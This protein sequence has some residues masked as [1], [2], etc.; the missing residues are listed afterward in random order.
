MTDTAADIGYGGEFR[1]GAG[2]GPVVY[3]ALGEVTA[4]SGIAIN[5]STVEA[6]HLKSPGAFKEF[7]AGL[8][9]LSEV[10]IKFNYVPGGT[11]EGDLTDDVIARARLQYQIFWPG[12]DGGTWSFKA[13]PTGFTPAGLTPEGKMEGEAKFKP[14]GAPTIAAV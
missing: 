9:D 5:G 8:L 6:T 7:I 2:S 13:I 11:L 10:T 14:S 1:K 12:T 3:T 4:I